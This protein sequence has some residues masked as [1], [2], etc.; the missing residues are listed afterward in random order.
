MN[1]RTKLAVLQRA[2]SYIATEDRWC[3]DNLVNFN[4][5]H[6]AI[7][8]VTA[9]VFKRPR[10]RDLDAWAHVAEI[11]PVLEVLAAQLPQDLLRKTA[12]GSI[13]D[14]NN[15]HTHKD[16]LRLFDEAIAKA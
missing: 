1:K 8:A 14:F 3:Q 7:G 11:K 5:Q 13:A 15:T 16:V 10:D 12:W 6:C 4:G 2:R 9:A